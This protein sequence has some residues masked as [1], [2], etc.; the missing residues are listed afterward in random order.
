M[1]GE[2]KPSVQAPSFNNYAHGE[3]YRAIPWALLEP[4][5]TT[6]RNAFGVVKLE[7]PTPTPNPKAISSWV[8]HEI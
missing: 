7:Q 6:E 5:D 3:I 2:L 8:S 1:K 4:D